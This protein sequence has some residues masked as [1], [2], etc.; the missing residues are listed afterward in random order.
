VKEKNIVGGR[1]SKAR[2][3]AKPPITQAD[4][5][6]RL[7]LLGIMIDQSTLSKIENRQRPVTDIQVVAL[8]KALKVSVAWLLEEGDC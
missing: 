3:A 8:A 4:L 5:I 6:A 7:Q 2:K 1:V